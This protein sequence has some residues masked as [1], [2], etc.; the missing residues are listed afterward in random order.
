MNGGPIHYSREVV[1]LGWME[2]TEATTE[3]QCSTV[4]GNGLDEYDGFS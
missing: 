4:N 1:D 3:L 2:T